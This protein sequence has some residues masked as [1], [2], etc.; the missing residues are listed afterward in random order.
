MAVNKMMPTSSAAFRLSLCVN[1]AIE[2]NNLCNKW[3]S[4]HCTNPQSVNCPGS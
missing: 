3:V 4:E 1:F 2:I